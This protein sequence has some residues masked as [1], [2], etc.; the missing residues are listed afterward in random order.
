MKDTDID[1]IVAGINKDL[2]ISTVVNFE[3]DRIDDIK[4]SSSGSIA[5]DLAL[6]GGYP[7]G[8][9][10]EIFGPESSGKT[11]LAIE[12]VVGVQKSGKIAAFLDF[13]HAFDRKYA[14]AIGVDFTK[15]KWLFSQPNSGE[16]GFTI[17]E[18]LLQ[19]K[20][21]GIIVI[22]S[23]AAMTPKAEIEGEFGES[24]M[25][26]HARLMGQGMRKLVG[27]INKSHC[28]IVFI[29]QERVK[30]GV[31]FGDPTTTTGGN[32]L[33][34]YAS[35]RLKITSAPKEEDTNKIAHSVRPRVTI[36]KNKIASPFK[37]CNFTIRFGEG[38]DKLQE[39]I[40]FAV[41]FN[42]IKK[43]GNWYSYEDVKL[44]QGESAVRSLLK[45][46]LE[47]VEEI[48]AKVFKK[49]GL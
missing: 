44:G 27:K 28:M 5:L 21:L 41:D 49:I 12:A 35:Q 32:A 9:I 4:V 34:F 42:I 20:E 15:G 47:L 40:E 18:R 29:N 17:I 10:I 37:K 7:Y 23:V 36:V 19:I 11:T 2:G 33:K 8:R 22:D 30:I 13:E 1:K 6:G 31:M 24:K 48:K 26:L 14:E 45:D 46:N 25:G 16:D 3:D 38:I 43:S 39:I